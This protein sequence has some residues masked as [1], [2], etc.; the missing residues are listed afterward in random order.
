METKI[1]RSMRKSIFFF[2]LSVT[3]SENRNEEQL[4]VE[5]S[6]GNG[7]WIKLNYVIYWSWHDIEM[8]PISFASA[9]SNQSFP[10]PPESAVMQVCV[11]VCVCV[12]LCT[13]LISPGRDAIKG[14]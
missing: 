14:Y 12:F 7:Y 13:V 3:A 2:F 8:D 4:C 6:L 10:K 5:G 11:C 9:P 1:P